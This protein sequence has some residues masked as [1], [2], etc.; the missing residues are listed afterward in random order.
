MTSKLVSSTGEKITGRPCELCWNT[1]IVS[2]V[3]RPARVRFEDIWKW[4][5]PCGCHA[6]EQWVKEAQVCLLPPP[7]EVCGRLAEVT[8]TTYPRCVKCDL[9]RRCA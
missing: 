4:Q 2:L 5:A 7:C 8:L 3:G 6:G 1:G 9:G